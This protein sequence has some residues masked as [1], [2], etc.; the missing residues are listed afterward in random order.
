MESLLLKPEIWLEW[1]YQ[2]ILIKPKVGGSLVQFRPNE[3]QQ[4]LYATMIAQRRAGFPVRIL[5]LK[6]RQPGIST[7][8]DCLLYTLVALQPNMNAFVCAQD[9]KASPV[10]FDRIRLAHSYSTVW[11]KEDMQ[12]SN[13]TELI[14]KKPH[15]S[16]FQVETAGK[17]TLKRSD[18]LQYAHLSEV[19]F[20]PHDTD[21]LVSVEQCIS[22]DP[23]TIE[24]IES[25]GQGDVGEFA[26]RWKRATQHQYDFADS[27]NHDLPNALDEWI[28]LFF[29]PLDSPDCRMPVPRNYQGGNLDAEEMQILKD[30]GRERA[31]REFFYW[32]RWT[33]RNRCGN[34]LDRLH[35]EHPMYPAEA[36]LSTGRPAISL[37]IRKRHMGQ[38]R[39]AK[40]AYLEW[41]DTAHTHVAPRY[42]DYEEGTDG[43]WQIWDEPQENWDYAIGAD[44]A[45]G[46]LADQNDYRS[47]PD[48]SAIAVLERGGLIT[49]AQ[50]RGRP[51]P[52]ELAIE[53]EKACVWYNHAYMTPE[54][55]NT[56]YSTLERLLADGYADHLY[57]RSGRI[58]NVIEV[59][60]Q[61]YGWLTDNAVSRS[62]LI[63]DWQNV[64]RGASHYGLGKT[65]KCYSKQLVDEETSFV[66]DKR[67]KSQHKSGKHYH[68]DVLF[69][70]MIAYRV[71]VS[72]PRQRVNVLTG[73][74]PVEG[75]RA[76]GSHCYDGG[77]DDMLPELEDPQEDEVLEAS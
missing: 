11:S 68:D 36:F 6:H 50:Y 13:R 35:T 65:I 53:M 48:Y 77:L 25:T 12:Y 75:G 67:G 47:E 15:N 33:L 8:V 74:R 27:S 21:A 51:S 73:M 32:R 55:N 46:E 45:T 70:W 43:V 30:F 42:M 72:C 7:A 20:W 2:N 9:D 5:V 37:E 39:G 64:C 59:I 66:V 31:T 44:V 49:A 14:W 28:P 10:L 23:D 4:K 38:V 71:H 16:R 63:Q 54:I 76:T 1:M 62:S 24:V 41:T 29:N 69:A 17:T 58:E 3:V 61:K 22:N 18:T 26:E 40:Y 57:Q 52:H 56:G 34:D 60:P 19:A